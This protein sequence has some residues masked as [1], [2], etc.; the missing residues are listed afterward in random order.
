[1]GSPGGQ[2]LALTKHAVHIYRDDDELSAVVGGYLAEGLLAG[3]GVIA[4]ATAPHRE[5]ITDAL[6]EAGV[7]VAEARQA[8]RL[9]A[10]D[11]AELLGSFQVGDQLD[12]ERFAAVV[13]GLLRRAAA[14]GRDVRV[15]GE[16]VAVLWEAGQPS[17]AIELER[18]WNGLDAQQPFQ[19]LCG[20]PAQLMASEE[21]ADAV[22]EVC[23]LH[24]DLRAT[25]SFL[26]ELDSVRA[27]RRFTGNL[28]DTEPGGESAEDAA[29]VVTE[30]AA[31]SV[32]HAR[33]GFT[34]S[35]A[36]SVAAVKIA[37][38]DHRPLAPRHADRP[39]DVQAGHGLGVVAQLAR[40]W[41]V[42]LL[43]DGKVVWAELALG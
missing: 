30:L 12:P 35:V 2:P 24:S 13:S 18:L 9:L 43:P 31:N 14:G 40:K 11:P 5:G 32:L 4:V 6:T 27:A 15:Y 7:D 41:A 23:R 42:D 21:T 38:R 17:L 34:L 28:L 33:S 20:Y 10:M 39:F 26:P 36:R 8:G 3:D 19:L 16:M 29:M 25:Q 37:V 1:M 22:G